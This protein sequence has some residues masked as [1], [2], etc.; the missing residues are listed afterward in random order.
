LESRRI[1]N[2]AH[3]I[4]LF[5]ANLNGKSSKYFLDNY[6]G[7]TKEQIWSMVPA[8]EAEATSFV[9]PGSKAPTT[10]EWVA[11][12]EKVWSRMKNHVLA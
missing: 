7:F 11:F 10:E 5:P 12:Q 1:L 6:L 4:T 2:E 3:S 9:P 8:E